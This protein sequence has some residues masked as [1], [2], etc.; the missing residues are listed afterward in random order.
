[1]VRIADSGALRSL[2]G[3][4]ALATADDP[5]IEGHPVLESLH[6]LEGLGWA[7][8]VWVEA[9]PGLVRLGGLE[10]PAQVAGFGALGVVGREVSIA[11]NPLLPRAEAEVLVD[12]LSS[13]RGTVYLSENGP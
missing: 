5:V 7:G 1:M 9:N 12:P 3:V 11:H 10:V 4:E 2:V 8:R 13:I 6:G